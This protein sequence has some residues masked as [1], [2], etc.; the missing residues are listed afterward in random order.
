M[1]ENRLEELKEEKNLKS[2]D[3][4]KYLKVYES[5][6]SEWEHNKIPLPTRR[7]IELADFYQVNIDYIL[8]MCD[9]KI[10]IHTKTTIDLNSIGK[11][12][13][14]TR[15]KLGLTLRELAHKINCSFSVIASYERGE[16]LINGDILISLCKLS[17]TS[18]DWILG[19]LN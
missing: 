13:K 10:N 17:N 19:R 8:K 12:L 4:A 7:I 6:Y 5:T 11:R 1:N 9:K 16:K 14:K 3:V 2:K 15:K 18:I